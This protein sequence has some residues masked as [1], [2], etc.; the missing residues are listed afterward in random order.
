MFHRLKIFTVHIKP[1]EKQPYAQ[2]VFVREGFNIY[3]FVLTFLW[4]LYH[5]LWIPAAGILAINFA[6][7]ALGEIHLISAGSVAILQFM[8]QILVGFH[9]N[10]WL[11]AGFAKRG[12]IMADVTAGDS[13]LRAEQRY[14]ERYLALN[15]A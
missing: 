14:F 13:L 12:Y 7:L 3:A 2:P 1:D 4:A 10:D 5:R 9:A 15:K 8:V 11:R 6:V